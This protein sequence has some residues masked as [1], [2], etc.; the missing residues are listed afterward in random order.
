MDIKE[1]IPSKIRTLS[2]NN[3]RFEKTDELPIKRLPHSSIQSHVPCKLMINS[4]TLWVAGRIRPTFPCVLYEVTKMGSRWQSVYAWDYT[5]LMY[6]L[7]SLHCRGC[8]WGRCSHV[9]QHPGLFNLE[10]RLKRPGCWAKTLPLF[11]N[12]LCPIPFTHGSTCC[13]LGC[14]IPL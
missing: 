3:N 4:F 13:W 11:S 1:R 8:T 5:G 6:N 12:L 14:T 10:S 2:L 9:A 7:Y